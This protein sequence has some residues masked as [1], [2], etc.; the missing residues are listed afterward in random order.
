MGM[1]E[2]E[3]LDTQVIEELTLTDAQIDM[4]SIGSE[5]LNLYGLVYIAAQPR[6]GKTLTAI[7]IADTIGAKNVLFLST[8]KALSSINSDCSK[9][10]P[11]FAV[12]AR[13]Y[14]QAHKLSPNYDLIVLDEAHKLGA[15]PKPSVTMQIVQRLTKDAKVILMSGT[16]TPESYSQIFHQLLATNKSPFPH[17]NFYKWAKEYVD[18]KQVRRQGGMLANDYSHA[19]EAK[20]TPVIQH[21]F[22]TKTQKEAGIT[23]HEVHETVETIP[24]DPKI[25]ALVKI[26]IKDRYYKFRDGDEIVADTSVALQ[27]KVHQLHSGTIK[28]GLKYKQLDISKAIHIHQKYG[29]LKIAIFYKYLGERAALKFVFGAHNIHDTP[30]EFNAAS[31]GVYISQVRSG[32]MGVNLST[33]NLL[34]FYNIDYSS[35]LYW[36]ARA[37]IQSMQ[38]TT[39]ANI[40]WV[41]S[42]GGI[43]HKIYQAVQGKKDYTNHYF[44]KD[45]KIGKRHTSKSA[46]VPA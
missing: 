29:H 35:M 22:V 2:V 44:K 40:V 26:L 41:F 13:N 12:T 5:I 6:A 30:E 17:P 43:E 14:E 1:I 36:Q 18:I 19:D 42:E 25:H 11:S 15:Y 33:A 7:H 9:Y 20:I 27:Q 28:V 31:S 4:A 10:R 45:F 34:V 38:R 16:P 39:P 21:L 24:I 8:L 3:Q 37:R 32:A 23:Q 46:K